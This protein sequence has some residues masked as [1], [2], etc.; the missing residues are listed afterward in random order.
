MKTTVQEIKNALDKIKHRLNI[1][2]EN[3]S[4]IEDAVTETIQNKIQREK[5][6]LE[7]L[8]VHWWN[9]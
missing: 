5:I 2:E 9:E 7:S 4:E 3:I 1:A 6:I 8:A